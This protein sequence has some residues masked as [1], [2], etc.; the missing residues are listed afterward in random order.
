MNPA[1]KPSSPVIT[2]PVTGEETAVAYLAQELPKARQSL[3]RTRIVGIILICCVAAYIGAISVIMVNF[4]QPKQAAEV[5]SG[6]LAQH[7]ASDGPA[8]AVQIEREIPALIRQMPDY[9]IKEIPNYRKQLQQ[10]LEGEFQSYCDSLSKDLGGQVDKLIDDHKAEIK[11]LLENANDREAIRKV[12]PDFERVITEFM[13]G[14]VDGKTLKKHIDDLA[15]ALKEVEKRM[16]RLANG[17]NLT[18]EEQRARRA[19]AMLAKV[20][21]DSAKVPDDA[22]VPPV[23]LLQ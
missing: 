23:E 2:T 19:L 16:D 10:T 12:L 14:D 13:Q 4:F 3:K 18:T 15:A 9:L 7:V 11:T 21:H 22:V 1:Q 20:I 17:K 5:A 8:L 6:M